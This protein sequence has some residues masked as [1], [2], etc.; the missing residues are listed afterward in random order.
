[1][2]VHGTVKDDVLERG[3]GCT[4][5]DVY[6]INDKNPVHYLIMVTEQLDLIVKEKKV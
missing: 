6:I 2:K 3:M 5:L 1:M 4:N